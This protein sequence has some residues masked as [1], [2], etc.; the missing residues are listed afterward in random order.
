ML[1]LTL[2]RQGVLTGTPSATSCDQKFAR[3][4][5]EISVSDTRVLWSKDGNDSGG[6]I[7]NFL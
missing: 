6:E 5:R 3:L 7:N 2:Q 1:E 4:R